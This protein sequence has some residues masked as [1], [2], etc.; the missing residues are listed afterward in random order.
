MAS[1][2]LRPLAR[3]VGSG[4]QGGSLGI[5]ASGEEV[6]ATER[7]HLTMTKLTPAPSRPL[8]RT[9]RRA[10]IA[11]AVV[12]TLGAASACSSATADGLSAAEALPAGTLLID[13]RTP[14]EF[15]E[16]HLEGAINISVESP[17][18]AAQVALLDPTADYLIY[19]RSG[20]RADVAMDF[21]A[22]AGF[23]S[24]RNLGSVAQASQA[25]GIRVVR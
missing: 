5:A 24:M 8:H 11:L 18:F 19:C 12:A 10:A 13:V 23:S 1:G 25:T 9:L 7:Y 2:A 6:R 16:G 22:E 17:A 4:L 20:R 3:G 15:S 14:S 21:M